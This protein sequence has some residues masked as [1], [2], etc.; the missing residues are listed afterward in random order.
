MRRQGAYFEE[1]ETPDR[2]VNYA[3]FSDP[4]Y[5]YLLCVFVYLIHTHALHEI[6]GME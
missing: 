2:E 6:C 1:T 5:Y 4:Y 3:I